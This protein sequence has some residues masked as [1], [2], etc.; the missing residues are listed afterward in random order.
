MKDQEGINSSN[1]SIDHN[2][3][4]LLDTIDDYK[5]IVLLYEEPESGRM[6]NFVL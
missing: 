5:H 2:P 3:L 6:I 4:K 1:D